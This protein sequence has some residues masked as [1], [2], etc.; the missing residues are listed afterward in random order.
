MNEIPNREIYEF[1]SNIKK[2]ENSGT[3]PINPDKY[4][5]Y[6]V[7]ILPDSLLFSINGRHTF[8]Y[9]RI[10]T[11]EKGQ[12][13]FGTPF[14]LLIDMQ[15]EGKWVGKARPEELP[16]KMVVDWVKFYELR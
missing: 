11:H 14:Y 9:P 10:E 3:A 8:T 5:I 4:N 13:P 16:A 6:A 1:Q 7:E 15:I 12:Y 2:P